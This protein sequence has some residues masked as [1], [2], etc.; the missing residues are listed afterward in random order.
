MK[1]IKMVS[2]LKQKRQKKQETRKDEKL[3]F[4]KNRKKMQT[5]ISPY[6]TKY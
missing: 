3:V 6:L 1:S 5:Y 2:N 4:Q